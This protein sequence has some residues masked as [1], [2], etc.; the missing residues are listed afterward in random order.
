MSERPYLVSIVEMGGY[1]DFS[2]LY[3]Q[4]GYEP[5]TERNM[6]KALGLIKK[7]QPRVVVAEFNYQSDFRDRTSSLETLMAVLQRMPDTRVIV[8]YEREQAEPYQRVSSRFPVHASL[9]FPV[10]E[11][12]LSAALA[13]LEE[14]A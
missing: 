13:E 12:A 10:D 14:T 4:A 7:K 6:R 2:A 5:L 8:F 1:P 3:R 9:T 11:S